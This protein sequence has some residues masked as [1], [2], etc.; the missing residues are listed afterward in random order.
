MMT[1]GTH[2]MLVV[3]SSLTVFF[4]VLVGTSC[5]DLD[6]THFQSQHVYRVEWQPGE[7]GYLEW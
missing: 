3:A 1:R 6:D 2:G 5:V 7:G 4:F